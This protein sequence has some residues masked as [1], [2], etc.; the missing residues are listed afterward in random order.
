[1]RKVIF[2]V[3]VTLFL[4][5][6]FQMVALIGPAVTGV[7]SGNITQSALSYTLSYGIKQSTGK[8]IIENVEDMIKNGEK[9]I[10]KNNKKNKNFKNSF[11]PNIYLSQ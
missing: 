9:K 5:G 3:I 8:T 4:N 11:S 2:L 1:M 10:A 6:C 7:T